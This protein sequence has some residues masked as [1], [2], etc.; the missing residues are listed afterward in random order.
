MMTDPT[1][2]HVSTEIL[3]GT[4]FVKNT[5]MTFLIVGEVS[6]LGHARERFEERFLRKS[7][8]NHLVGTLIR[9]TETPSQQVLASS[10]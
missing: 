7:A 4:G 9:E 2:I 3:S 6:M 5:V 1:F 10:I 8:K